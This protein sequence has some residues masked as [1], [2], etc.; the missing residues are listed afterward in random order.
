MKTL[1]KFATEKVAALY[2]GLHL[3]KALGKLPPSSLRTMISTIRSATDKL[4]DPNSLRGVGVVGK[5]TVWINREPDPYK[6]GGGSKREVLA[7]EIFHARNPKLGKSEFLARFYGGFKSK[8]GRIP[9]KI[10]RG[11]LSA[12]HTP[13]W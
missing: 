4:K 1:H 13:I 10:V 3:S 8:K 5:N 11:L 2:K 9:A 7:H 6:F 12:G